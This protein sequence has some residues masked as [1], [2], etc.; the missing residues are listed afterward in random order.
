[1]TFTLLEKK[2]VLQEHKLIL[3][4]DLTKDLVSEKLNLVNNVLKSFE[5]KTNP[6]SNI[7]AAYNEFKTIVVKNHTTRD[8]TTNYGEVITALKNF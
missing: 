5:S 6:Y 1:M 2:L 7:E 3:N 8:N 4:E